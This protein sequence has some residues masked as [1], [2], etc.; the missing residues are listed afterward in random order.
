MAWD[1]HHCI[2]Y[3]LRMDTALADLLRNH[4]PARRFE[5]LFDSREGVALFS[6]AFLKLSQP[7]ARLLPKRLVDKIGTWWLSFRLSWQR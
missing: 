3:A 4:F 1:V 5:V 6:H 7:G 2:E